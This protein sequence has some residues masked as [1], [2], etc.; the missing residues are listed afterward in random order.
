MH[1]PGNVDRHPRQEPREGH[2][3]PEDEPAEADDRHPPEDREVVELLPVGPAPHMWPRRKTEEPLEHV[4]EVDCIL[5]L[6]TMD[7][8]PTASP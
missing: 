7:L 6:G 2:R 8:G 4:R 5:R 1:D 3:Q